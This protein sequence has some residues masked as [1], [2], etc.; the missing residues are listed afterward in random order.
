MNTYDRR[1]KLL[2]S[3]TGAAICLALC[4]YLPF[5]TGQIPSVGQALCPMHIPVLLAGFVC[6]PWWAMAVGLIAPLM[7]HVLFS[8]PP[9]ITAL[10]MCVELAAY[11]LISGGLYRCLP[12]R[13]GSIYLSLILA[14]AGGRLAWGCGMVLLMGAAG[15]GF[16]WAAFLTGAFTGAIPGILLQILLIP[17]VVMALQRAGVLDASHPRRAAV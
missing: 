9:L 13:N 5:V 15:S 4:L 17:I 10:A 1:G 12:K 16:T 6:G 14:M 2:R 3:M 7:R 8:M 11:G